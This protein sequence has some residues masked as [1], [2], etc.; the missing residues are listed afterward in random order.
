MELNENLAEIVGIMLGDGCLYKEKK[1]NRYQ[2][3]ICFHKEE[4]DYQKYV[5][6]L[7]ESY[8]NHKFYV[9]EIKCENLLRN[10]SFIVGDK[11]TKVGLSSGNK[12][13]NK[14]AIPF[15]ITKDEN[16]LRR[17]VR[18]LFDTDGCIYKKYGHYA[19][20]VFKFGGFE[21]TDSLRTSLKSLGFNPTQVK[22]GFNREKRTDFYKF[23]LSRQSEIERFFIEI[24]PKNPKHLERYQKIKSGAAGI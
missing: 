23:Y 7:F 20:I 2:T 19:Q 14:A 16:F 6:T 11:L 12:V 10:T 15:W 4:K 1:R 3:I 22:K 13:S 21:M 24:M 8:F 18:G 17:T 5:K 9:T